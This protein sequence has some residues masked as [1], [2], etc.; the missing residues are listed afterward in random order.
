M[1]LG[2]LAHA[3]AQG[4]ILVYHRSLGDGESAVPG[5]LAGAAAGPSPPSR[6]RSSPESSRSGGSGASSPGAAGPSAPAPVAGQHGGS[7]SFVLAA[8]RLPVVPAV[9]PGWGMTQAGVSSFEAAAAALAEQYDGPPAVDRAEPP[10]MLPAEAVAEQQALHALIVQQVPH[11]LLPPLSPASSAQLRR[12]A[13]S[14]TGASIDSRGAGLLL[15]YLASRCPAARGQRTTA[16]SAA[17]NLQR[18]VQMRTRAVCVSCRITLTIGEEGLRMFVFDG[19][20]R[21]HRTTKALCRSL[22]RVLSP[23]LALGS[24]N[25]SCLQGPLGHLR[26]RP[27][28]FRCGPPHRTCSARPPQPPPRG[29]PASAARWTSAASTRRSAKRCVGAPRRLCSG[30][31]LLSLASPSAVVSRAGA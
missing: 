27:H 20:L 17:H 15:V 24:T 6:S 25:A 12:H 29:G 30:H 21:A 10:S 19:C 26:P 28:Q 31:T 9:L 23:R 5:L 7:S 13:S 1:L 3:G 16:L 11:R 22:N 18:R 14:S 2:F 4:L 8:S